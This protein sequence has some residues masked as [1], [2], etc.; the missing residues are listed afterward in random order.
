MNFGVQLM[1]ESLNHGDRFSKMYIFEC[2]V[3][4]T[5]K[6]KFRVPISADNLGTNK[7]VLNVLKM[8]KKKHNAVIHEDKI[9]RATNLKWFFLNQI[10]NWKS[11]QHAQRATTIVFQEPGSYT[12]RLRPTLMGVMWDL[13]EELV[14]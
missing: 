4:S 6:E 8:L 5:E 9:S 14:C 2:V 3:R 11:L 10:A 1:S 12:I 7:D 13:V